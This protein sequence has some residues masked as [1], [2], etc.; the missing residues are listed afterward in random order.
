MVLQ[1]LENAMPEHIPHISVC[2][3]TY[4]RSEMLRK[5]LGEL[6]KI[7]TGGLFSYAAVIIDNDYEG[8]AKKTI[9]D[10]SADS[11]IGLEY[12]I[13]PQKNIALARNMAIQKARG[14]YV[15]FIDDDEFPVSGWLLNLY[16]ACRDFKADGVLGPIRPHFEV[17]PPDWI[18]KGRFCERPEYKTGTRLHW[19]RTRTGNVLLGRH[20][21]EGQYPFNPQFAAGGED[22]NFFKEKMDKG[23]VFV[24]CNEATVYETVPPARLRASFFIKRK[25]LQGNISV[26]YQ[27]TMDRFR[28]KAGSC[29]KSFTAFLLYTAILPF[30]LL[31][32][33]H[34]FMKYMEKDIYHVGRLLAIF[35]LVAVK[36]RNL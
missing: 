5:L 23:H 30:T 32:G 3:C 4:K 33:F 34:V 20:L 14:D 17:P 15:A 27:G 21:L 31:A 24:W 13:Q 29:I 7:E 19:N 18:L 1:P 2:I 16:Q 8:S 9:E 11:F 22:V 26:L 6:Q 36:N 28:D 25:F 12:H 10:I 35:G